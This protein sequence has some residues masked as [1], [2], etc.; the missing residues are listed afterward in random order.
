MTK[1]ILL[2]LLACL[3]LVGIASTSQALPIQSE[4]PTN[5][6]STDD[7]W[8]YSYLAYD[9]SITTA[10]SYF[11]ANYGAAVSQGYVTGDYG[12]WS[13]SGV[14]SFSS[15]GL[16]DSNTTHVFETY[17]MSSIDQTVLFRMSGD[18][19]HSI[20]VNDTW[21]DEIAIYNAPHYNDSTGT[22][23]IDG[24]YDMGA[25]GGFS[26]TAG[27]YLTMEADTQYKLSIILNNRSGPWSAWF[28]TTDT[29]GVVSAVSDASNISMNAAGDFAAPVPEPATMLLFGLGLLG[30]AGVN[31][32]KK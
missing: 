20:L 27:R 11:I 30:L 12:P 3:L 22:A 8:E 25:G 6:T 14:D 9:S 26:Y 28:H 24:Y 18:D 31:R 5:P 19:G 2:G 4:T 32:R 7:L 29:A 1:K 15:S 21:T 16:S 13:P 17:I 23:V 10:Y